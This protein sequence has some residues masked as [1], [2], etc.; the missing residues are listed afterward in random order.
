M[1]V[2]VGNPYIFLKREPEV[3]KDTPMGGIGFVSSLRS[4]GYRMFHVVSG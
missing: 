3:V 1:A 2:V 4:S